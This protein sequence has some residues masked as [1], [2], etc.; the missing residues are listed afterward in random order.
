MQN[1]PR[2]YCQGY[3][4]GYKSGWNDQ[5]DGDANGICFPGMQQLILAKC[6]SGVRL[7]SKDYDFG[8]DKP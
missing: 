4:A 1:C 7:D 8:W 5:L 2:T 3:W 6:I